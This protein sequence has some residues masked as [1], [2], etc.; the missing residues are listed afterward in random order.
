[1][2]N[3]EPWDLLVWWEWVNSTSIISEYLSDGQN[4]TIVIHIKWILCHWHGC[5]LGRKPISKMSICQEIESNNHLA[6]YNGYGVGNLLHQKHWEVHGFPRVVSYTH[7]NDDMKA[8]EG[9][10][11]WITCV[12]LST[13]EVWCQSFLFFFWSIPARPL[14]WSVRQSEV[15]WSAIASK[16][17]ECHPEICLFCCGLPPKKLDKIYAVEYQIKKIRVKQKAPLRERPKEAF[18][19]TEQMF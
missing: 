1:M 3:E 15:F 6:F 2:H 17:L 5:N 11:Y 16:L 18:H 4:G 8:V 9:I 12:S 13:S 19:Q 7:L 10:L 14:A